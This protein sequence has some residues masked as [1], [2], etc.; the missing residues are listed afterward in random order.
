SQVGDILRQE[1]ELKENEVEKYSIGQ[2]RQYAGNMTKVIS[3]IAIVWAVFQLYVNSFGVMENIKHR[4]WFFGFMAGLIFLLV[5]ARKREK[6]QRK[7]PSIWDIVCVIGAIASVGY[8]LTMY[9]AY[10]VDRGGLHIQPDYWFGT[11]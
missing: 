10:V 9:D 3:V 6:K 8:F 1:A 11:L 5:P 2:F 4:V 7:L